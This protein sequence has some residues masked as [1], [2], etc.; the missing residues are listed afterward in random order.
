LRE[1][2][3]SG[4]VPQLGHTRTQDDLNHHTDIQ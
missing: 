2:A 4:T 3:L 1:Q